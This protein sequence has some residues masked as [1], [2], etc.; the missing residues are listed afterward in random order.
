MKTN[1]WLLLFT[2]IGLFSTQQTQAQTYQPSNRI[3]IADNS[4]IGTQVSGANNNFDITGGLQ[5]GQN[6]FHSFQDFSVPTGGS[7]NFANSAG[8][9]SIITRVTGN[10]F[11]DINGLIKTNG[12]NFLLINPQGVV[13]G[14]GVSLDVGKA[15]VTS[16][17]N[18]IN[19]V[20]GGGRSITFGTNPNGDAPLL[21]IAPDVLFNVSSLN[22]GAGSGAISNFG[23]L[24]TANQGQY[25]GLVG[26]NVNLDG[27]KI[28]APGGRVD[29]GG[30]N[31]AGTVS[32]NS[33]GLVFDGIGLT[34]SN[35]SIANGS[36]I[37]V[38]ASQTLSPVDPV[39][40]P[41]AISPGS[42]IN[43]SAN[44]IDL[45]NSGS[46]FIANTTNPTNQ[47]LGGLD[48]GLAVNS[49]TKTGKIGKINLNA[50]GDINLN[51]SAIFNVVRSG[52][53]GTGG[54]I[55]LVG[56]NI[57]ITNK[58]EISNSLAQ[59]AAGQGGDIEINALGN[60]NFAQ[61]NYPGVK[62]S[63]IN[64]DTEAIAESLIAASTYGRGNAG[65]V[66]IA[67]GGSFVVGDNS[68]ITSK[69]ATTGSG[70]GG[71]IKIDASSVTIRNGGQILTTVAEDK[72]GRTSNAKNNAGNIEINAKGDV[73]IFGSSTVNEDRNN[74]TRLA[75]IESNNFRVGDS[76]QVNINALNGKLSILNRG[77]IISSIRG[78]GNG[79]SNSINLNVK[80]LLLGNLSE[81]SSSLGG[82]SADGQRETKMQGKAGDINIQAIGD[83][84][85]N[86]YLDSL[87]VKKFEGSATGP[88]G[89]YSSI[90][91]K[92][93]EDGGKITINTLGKV[94]VGNHDV[95]NSA[96]EREGEGS[97]GG[98]EINAREL[99]VFNE[100]QI[101]TVA[102]RY[103][104]NDITKTG[105]AGNIDIKTTGNVTVAGNQDPT[106]GTNDA[107]SNL[108][109]IASNSFRN[110]NAGKITI[111]AGGIVSLFNKGGIVTQCLQDCKSQ[112]TNTPGNITIS[113]RQ[114]KLDR[115]D[116]STT[117][118]DKGGNILLNAPDL[119]LMRRNSQ[120]TTDSKGAGNGGNIAIDSKFILA[121]NANND[122]TANAIKGQGGNVKINAQ[123]VF[124]I[125]F[126]SQ[127]SLNTSD[128]TASS[129]FGQSGNVQINTPG[130]DP[131]KD[132][133]ELVAVPNDASKQIS[134]TCSA[135][136]RQNKLTVTGRG[137]LP[138][139]AS[140]PLVGDVI[141][142][143]ARAIEDQP[144]LNNGNQQTQPLDSPAIGWTFD[145]QGK[146]TLVAASS[147]GQPTTA[148]VV[149]PAVRQ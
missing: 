79:R 141:W 97:P 17:A 38:R 123:G 8:N 127:R 21:T 100:G 31:T 16:T 134:Q 132:K 138:P 45:F 29:I 91:G 121:T 2:P 128:I 57:N 53:A 18:G 22:L 140:D 84:I 126:R 51:Q 89:I 56:N 148:N 75:R 25:I 42:S 12:A 118:T 37:S 88:S 137:G 81:I 124:G 109:K 115:G 108:A 93:T 5:R 36:S 120:I 3:P 133:G 28:I 47:A 23:T 14:K 143:D 4:Q 125:Q 74:S 70:N 69:V 90:N 130:V 101:L 105:N 43:L 135:S 94:S 86:E 144:K 55:K 146:V 131:A 24:Q 19:L 98:I 111:E 102:A 85:V 147:P 82:R 48:A 96:I 63:L 35:V 46:R 87:I 54:R 110:G 67:A 99:E 9:Q 136:N 80:E 117:S 95:I 112:V 52:A 40:F 122:I 66:Q 7:A 60:F 129:D 20:D 26:G 72:T 49:G 142:L 10:L 119:I 33:D 149:C 6:L 73:T 64:A 41:T 30:L 62:A 58:S 78:T 65:K 83:V 103:R 104:G 106:V 71:G 76:G 44:Q 50:T 113:S 34:R 77:A 39:F 15:F 27:G 116:I 59:K 139:T 107:E 13:F 61:A 11:S 68:A 114:I 1:F 92:A 145:G 32:A